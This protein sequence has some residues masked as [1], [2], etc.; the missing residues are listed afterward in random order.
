MHLVMSIK[1]IAPPDQVRRSFKRFIKNIYVAM[2]MIS[3]GAEQPTKLKRNIAM[4]F[5][6]VYYSL[7]S[8]EAQRQTNL[9]YSQPQTDSAFDVSFSYALF[10]YHRHGICLIRRLLHK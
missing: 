2:S 8:S 6:A 10:L 3:T 7:L 1:E 4:G 9:F 5:G